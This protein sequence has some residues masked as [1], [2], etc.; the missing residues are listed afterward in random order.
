MATF[1]AGICPPA[2]KSRAAHLKAGSAWCRIVSE[3]RGGESDGDNPGHHYG[4]DSSDSRVPAGQLR[5]DWRHLLL[6]RLP[7]AAALFLR[8]TADRSGFDGAAGLVPG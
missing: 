1:W 5:A 7:R 2:I 3:P 4:D 6:A 8:A